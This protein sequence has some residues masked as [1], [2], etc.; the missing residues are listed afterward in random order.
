MWNIGFTRLAEPAPGALLVAEDDGD[1]SFERTEAEAQHPES[2]AKLAVWQRVLDWMRGNTAAPPSPAASAEV[3]S[4]AELV[5][6]VA[7]AY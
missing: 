6:C 4:L 5:E 2:A 7:Y 3:E 1:D